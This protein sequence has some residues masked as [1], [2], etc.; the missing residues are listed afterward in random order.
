MRSL[1][2]CDPVAVVI[3][4]HVY[5]LAVVIYQE[6]IFLNFDYNW[7]IHAFLKLRFH[8]V[9]PLNLQSQIS[10]SSKVIFFLVISSYEKPQKMQFGSAV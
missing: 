9:R 6:V 4:F 7:A 10:S 5:Y 8:I 1:K 3:L 2:A